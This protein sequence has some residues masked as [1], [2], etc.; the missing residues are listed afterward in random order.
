MLTA[1]KGS[2]FYFYSVIMGNLNFMLSLVEHFF[3]LWALCTQSPNVV[4]RFC[5]LV[6]KVLLIFLENVQNMQMGLLG[7]SCR[8]AKT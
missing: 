4:A 7:N 3:N 6:V 2:Q 5:A 8:K 1:L